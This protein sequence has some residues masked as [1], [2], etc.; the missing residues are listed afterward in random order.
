[1]VNEKLGNAE[2]TPYASSDAFFFLLALLA[3]WNVY[4]KN[5]IVSL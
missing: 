2:D 5:N 1:M 4:K 3:S